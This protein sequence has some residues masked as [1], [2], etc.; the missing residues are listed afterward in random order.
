MTQETTPT[1]GGPSSSQD[2]NQA[3]NQR[4]GLLGWF[5]SNAYAANFLMVTLIVAGIISIGIVKQQVLPS[6]KPNEVSVSVSY[7]GAS[8]D[9]I[10]DGVILPIESEVEGLDVVKRIESTAVEGLGT[11]RVD[12]QD[13]VN[14]DIALQ[15]IRNAVDTI[16][17]FPDDAEPPRTDLPADR[18]QVLR[19]GIVVDAPDRE[20]FDYANA[21]KDRLLALSNVSQVTISGLREPEIS[22]EIPEATL[23]S[24]DLSYDDIAAIVSRFSVDTPAGAIRSEGRQLLLRGEG[25]KETASDFANVPIASGPRGVVRLGD[26]ATLRDGFRDTDRHFRINGRTGFAIEIYQVGDQKPLDVAAAVETLFE[27]FEAEQPDSVEIIKLFDLTKDYRER[28]GL[29]TENGVLGFVLILVLLALFLEPRVAFWVAAGVPVALI[30]ALSVFP[31]FGVSINMLSLFAFILVL[32]VVVDDAIIVGEAIFSRIEAGVS[33]SEA[34]IQGAQRMLAPV[35]L[36]VATNIIAFAPLL[37]APGELGQ[38]L[39]NIPMVATIVFV[40][41][42]IEALLIL[43][44]HLAHAA[45]TGGAEDRDTN[46]A[47]F[48]GF[49]ERISSAAS[50]GFSNFEQKVYAPLV[51]SAVASPGVTT[52]IFVAVAIVVLGFTISGRLPFRLAPSV[53]GRGVTATYSLAVS[54]PFDAT[55]A[56]AETLIDAAERA[57]EKIGAEDAFIA[58]IEDLGAGGNETGSVNLVFVPSEE[59]DFGLADFVSVWR[60]EIPPV[61]DI[62][63]FSI[64]YRIGPGAGAAFEAELS[65]PDIEALRAISARAAARVAEFPGATDIDDGFALGKPQYSYVLTREGQALGLTESDLGRALRSRFEGAEARRQ[66]RGQDELR[67][68]VRPPLSDIRS[69][70][71]LDKIVVNNAAGVEA[72]LGDIAEYRQDRAFQEIN[73][74]DGKTTVTVSADAD[75]DVIEPTALMDAFANQIMPP[76]LQEYPQLSWRFGGQAEEDREAVALLQT[77]SAG[78][79]FLIFSI[80]AVTFRSLRLAGVVMATIPFSILAAFVGHATLGYAISFLS[81]FGII[82]L[83]GLVI[84][85]SLVLVLRYREALEEGAKARDALIDA[86]VRRFRPITLTAMTTTA[87]LTPLLFEQSLQAQFLVPMAISLSFGALFSVFVVLIFIPA[88]A[89]LVTPEL[90]NAPES[91]S[92]AP[93]ADAALARPA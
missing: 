23:R 26:V 25:R 60:R 68:R 35:L 91:K 82:A 57:V 19:Y 62:E 89:T 28:I 85:G 79:V 13:G 4:I 59:R 90:R 17:T 41:S 70:G 24:L 44:A 6:V 12:L 73:R 72:F 65:H 51:R 80:L 47:S 43:P 74:V 16:Q 58:A 3:G 55:K 77:G 33:P 81:I 27:E 34:A 48:F 83:S 52:V 30:S 39:V 40:F 29:L 64:L 9:E 67:I 86:A 36:A 71:A 84:N 93:D 1:S 76:L 7:L 66:L 38:F 88:F 75:T 10:V 53:E 5:A 11:V 63:S 50:R 92:D 32:G 61:A 15:D 45:K 54:A 8:P 69:E 20:I 56:Y 87:G 78:A 14:R 21:L 46:S 42:L 49:L 31:F 18:N 22:I 2:A 37:F